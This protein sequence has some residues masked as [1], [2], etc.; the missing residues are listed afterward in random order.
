VYLHARAVDMKQEG[1]EN[2][3]LDLH[4]S[5]QT[6]V[7]KAMRGCGVVFCEAG[8]VAFVRA[9]KSVRGARILCGQA[10]SGCGPWQGA[11]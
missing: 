8:R 11:I 2:A 6:L 5:D 9:V 4:S 7:G 1:E 10:T 3:M